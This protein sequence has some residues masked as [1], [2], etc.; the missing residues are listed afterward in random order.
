MGKTFIKHFKPVE[1]SNC[2]R[3]NSQPPCNLNHAN[4]IKS[5]IYIKLNTYITLDISQM[6]N[7]ESRQVKHKRYILKQNT[8]AVYKILIQQAI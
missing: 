5:I 2:T 4:T 8:K 1:K 3:T 7:Y 6:I